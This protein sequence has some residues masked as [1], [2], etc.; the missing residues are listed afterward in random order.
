[1]QK[2]QNQ[3]SVR[4]EKAESSGTAALSVLR[5]RKSLTFYCLNDKITLVNGVGKIKIK[6]FDF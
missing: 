4:V 2:S 3:T 6:N 1:M 5:K